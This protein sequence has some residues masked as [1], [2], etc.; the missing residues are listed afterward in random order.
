MVK[1]SLLIMLLLALFAPWAA[2]QNTYYQK[3]TQL[4]DITSTG[5]YILVNEANGMV[6]LTTPTS[7]SSTTINPGGPVTIA[8]GIIETSDLNNVSNVAYLTI[9]GTLGETSIT[10]TTIQNQNNYQFKAKNSTALQWNTYGHDNWVIAFNNGNLRIYRT[11]D[12]SNTKSYVYYSHGTSTYTRYFTIN[13]TEQA[14]TIAL[15]KETVASNYPAPKNLTVTSTTAHE[16]TLT[17]TSP[18]ENLTGYAYQYKKTADETWSTLVEIGSSVLTCTINELDA[19]TSYDFR[20]KAIY[21]DDPEINFA[22]TSFTTDAACPAP[23]GLAVTASGTTVT[24]TWTGSSDSYDVYYNTTGSAPD[25]STT[26]NITGITITSQTISNLSIDNTYYVWVR[27]NCTGEDPSSWTGPESVFL[28]YCTPNPSSVDGQ[29]ITNVTFGMG[30]EIVNNNNWPT[31][32]PYYGNYSAQIGAI[33]QGTTGNVN[34]TYSTGSST[35]Y[36]YG[37]LIWVDWNNNL[38]FEDSEI[39]YT[40]TSAQGSGG[41]P[42]LLVADVAV[43]SNQDLGYYRM[44]IAGADTYFDSY[45]GGN[46]TGNHS[47]CFTSTYAVCHDYTIHVIE[48]NECSLVPSNFAFNASYTSAAATWETTD[49]ESCD[50]YWSTTNAAPAPEDTPSQAGITG[51]SNSYSYNIGSLTAGTTYYVWIRVNCGENSHGNWTSAGNFTTQS[52]TAP[53]VSEPTGITA[54]S[55][56]IA[57]TAPNEDVVS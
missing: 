45:I 3:V 35:V 10:G 27:S 46:S 55:A 1:K 24:V 9:S 31:S 8:S 21:E 43:P 29:G 30:T 51:E 7:S 49:G 44:R 16:A 40:G 48:A 34:I 23:T 39:V 56:T 19:E 36:S 2:G 4:S 52:Y 54:N 15:Y 33:E 41:V 25:A 5:K 57:W 20:V 47:A 22:T 13:T 32:A 14:G 12:G 18:S 11:P 50:I 42:Q 53:T 6:A 37:T 38:T 28:G 26:P 17:W